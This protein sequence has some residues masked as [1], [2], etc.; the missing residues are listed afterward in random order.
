MYLFISSEP[1]EA[2]NDPI[3]ISSK[4]KADHVGP[5]P[6]RTKGNVDAYLRQGVK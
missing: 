3:T 4:R 6:K 1:C 2:T 5:K